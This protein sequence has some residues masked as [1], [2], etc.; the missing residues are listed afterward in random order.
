MRFARWIAGLHHLCRADPEGEKEEHHATGHDAVVGQILGQ[1]AEPLRVR[2][3]RALMDEDPRCAA[4]IDSTA[5]LLRGK[6][7]R[8]R[9]Y[10]DFLDL[11]AEIV[12]ACLLTIGNAEVRFLP[13]RRRDAGRTPEYLVTHPASDFF[14]ECRRIREPS[15]VVITPGSPISTMSYSPRHYGGAHDNQAARRISDAILSKLTQLHPD[16]PNVLFLYTSAFGATPMFFNDAL[17]LLE[18]ADDSFLAARGYRTRDA[19]LADVNR[20]SA[21]AYREEGRGGDRPRNL[22]TRVQSALHPLPAEILEWLE[23]LDFLGAAVG[24]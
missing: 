13:C 22:V 20:I 24:L 6:F 4:L 8:A 15:G 21:I 19:F 16:R 9:I 18:G 17:R 14:G 7:S 12:W 3:L 5:N 10:E 1:H 2:R 23:N 11:F